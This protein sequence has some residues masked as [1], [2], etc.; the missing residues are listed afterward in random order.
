MNKNW[1]KIVE[2]EE[3]DVLVQRRSNDDDGE[4]I[5]VSI[6]MDG[7]HL[8]LKLTGENSDDADAM[9]E[10]FSKVDA[11]KIVESFKAMLS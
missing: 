9:Y 1:C 4:H 7:M 11:E 6:A 10:K 5:K 3:H 8:S 2:L